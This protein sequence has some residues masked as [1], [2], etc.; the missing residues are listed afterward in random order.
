[1]QLYSY[2]QQAVDELQK[3]NKGLL[4]LPT[5]AG[6]TIVFMSDAKNRIAEAKEL[7]TFVIVAPRILLSEQLSDNFIQFIKDEDIYITNVHSGG[8]Q[9]TTKVDKIQLHSR[10]AKAL[11]KHHFIF[12]T[13]NS[14]HK[15]NEGTS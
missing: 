15:V 7:M 6:K 8:K 9:A 2:Q 11:N 1:M 14:L 4:T 10:I 3:H 5:G 12:T 13:Y